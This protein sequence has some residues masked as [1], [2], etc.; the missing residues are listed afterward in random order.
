MPKILL[1]ACVPHSL[2]R[3]LTGLDAETAQFAGLDRITDSALLDAM[4]GRYDILVT[5]DRNLTYQQKIAGRS[6]AVIVLR[7]PEQTPEAFS[8]PVPAL[9]QAI[10]EAS[11]GQAVVIGQ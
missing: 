4:A 11:A 6:V 2:R 1:D 8:A 7:V 10:E 5:L 3:Y 9:K